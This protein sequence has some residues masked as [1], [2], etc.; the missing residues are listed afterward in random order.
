MTD[1]L[2]SATA[3]SVSH[4]EPPALVPV[5][6]STSGSFL[7]ESEPTEQPVL[8]ELGPAQPPA[9]V[10]SINYTLLPDGGGL[11]T[12]GSPT[13]HPNGV[14][15][16]TDGS[17][18]SLMTNSGYGVIPQPVTMW[19]LPQHTPSQPPAVSNI[20]SK[21]SELVPPPMYMTYGGSIGGGT[22]IA[23]STE[24]EIT[25][26]HN[27]AWREKALQM[28]KDYR[29]TACDRERTRM[30]DMN[31]AFDLLRSKLPISKP[32]GKKYSKI[33]SLRIAINY[34]NH[35]QAMLR[36][37]HLPDSE[38]VSFRHSSRGVSGGSSSLHF[39][40]QSHGN[41]NSSSSAFDYDNGTSASQNGNGCCG[42][43]GGSSSSPTYDNGKDHW[44]S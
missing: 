28:E 10:T 33:E 29:R 17:G 31:R 43:S 19:P 1:H 39:D 41:A 25:K 20:D 16:S 42:W 21:S 26:E 12:Y 37:N 44:G 32:N 24:V 13:T 38:M 40:N 5:P 9:P 4:S 11:L 22:N 15:Y 14:S 30:R 36:E 27:P 2:L 23:N 7:E 3:A 18:L 35:L 8:L 6:V 34:I